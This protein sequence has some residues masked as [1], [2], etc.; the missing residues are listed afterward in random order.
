MDRKCLEEALKNL[1]DH[2]QQGILEATQLGQASDSDVDDSVVHGKESVSTFYG[3]MKKWIPVGQ[4]ARSKDAWND[5]K[6]KVDSFSELADGWNSYSAPR[7]ARIAIRNV[8][9]FLDVLF[10]ANMKPNRIRPSAVGGIGVTFRRGEKKS[11]VEFLNS[12]STY[13]LFSDGVEEP[14]VREISG[15]YRDYLRL[16]G[17]IRKYLNA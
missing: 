1:Q 5:L 4:F 7:P 12:G 8:R 15:E 11:Y 17:E 3:K 13:A 16:T 2:L 9:E 10:A 6:A 14:Q